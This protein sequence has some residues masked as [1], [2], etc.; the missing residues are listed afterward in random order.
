MTRLT[1]TAVPKASPIILA[2]LGLGDERH[3]AG[4]PLVHHRGIIGDAGGETNNSRT[5]AWI[6]SKKIPF[7]TCHQLR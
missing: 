1:T 5:E 3:T 2:L 4:A 7:V 6:I